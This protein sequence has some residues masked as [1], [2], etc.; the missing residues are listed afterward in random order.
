MF[1]KRRTADS[2][3]IGPSGGFDAVQGFDGVGGG[4]RAY[5]GR[6]APRVV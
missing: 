2:T 6:R 1:E 3:A 4:N 5:C